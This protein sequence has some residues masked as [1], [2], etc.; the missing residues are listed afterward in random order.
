MKRTLIAATIAALT[1]PVGFAAPA[2]AYDPTE[3]NIRVDP[4]NWTWTGT[5]S[6][7]SAFCE[8]NECATT[9]ADDLIHSATFTALPGSHLDNTVLTEQFEW[10]KDYFVYLTD[11]TF[12]GGGVT[13]TGDDVGVYIGNES[14]FNNPS[15][16]KS[17]VYA[18]HEEGIN[19]NFG[20]PGGSAWELKFYPVD[21]F[22]PATAATDVNTAQA[23]SKKTN[24]V[25]LQPNRVTA[26]A[27]RF[28]AEPGSPINI[29][30]YGPDKDVALTRAEHVRDHLLTE[31][32]RLGGDPA[33]YPTVVVYAGNPDHKKN[34]HVTIH[35]HAPSSIT[36]PDGGTLTIGG[37]S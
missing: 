12:T 2:Q 5:I 6:I 23:R 28:I 21:S 30:G 24:Y 29:H 3:V 26:M 16:K 33:D 10:D 9:L 22:P 13:R 35:Q 25:T 8:G 15:E 14:L 11:N 20:Q 18:T 36:V 34:V 27:K 1:I 37:A 7:Y 4:G 19:H 31:I 17:G 32:A